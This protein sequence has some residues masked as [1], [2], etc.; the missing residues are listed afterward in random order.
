MHHVYKARD[1]TGM[2][3]N[4]K[5][6]NLYSYIR[7]SSE[8]Q[9]QG[10]SH[11]RQASQARQFAL[12][13][14]LN[15]IEVLDSGVSAYR[16]A[17][18]S[19]G[20]LGSFIAAVE[21][22]AIPS[23]SWLYV[24]NLDRISRQAIT[25]SQEL[26]LK[27]LRLG[28]TIVTGI[29]G[30]IYTTETVN[31]NPTD[32]MLSILLFSRAH[33]ESKTK[34]DRTNKNVLTLIDRHNAGLPVNIK[35]AGKHPFWIDDSGSQYETVRLHA[36]YAPAAKKSIE[37]FL[38]GW[39]SYRVC[40]YLNDHYEC[41]PALKYKNKHGTIRAEGWSITALRKMRDNPALFGQRVITIQNKTY[42]LHNYYPPLI[43][44]SDFIKL[45]SIK[46]NN[47]ITCNK[48]YNTISLLSGLNI[49]RCAKC[50]GPMSFFTHRNK[51]RYVCETGKSQKGCVPW[52]MDG[53]IA[54]RLLV[55]PLLKSFIDLKLKGMSNVDQ[56]QHK[57]TELNEALSNIN[58]QISNYEKVIGAGINLDSTIASLRA[59]QSQRET[60]TLELNKVNE[61]AAL[62]NS[63][64]QTVEQIVDFLFDNLT[65]QIINDI[66][67]PKRQ[68]LRETIRNLFSNVY[69]DKR[70]DKTYMIAFE[71][72]DDSFVVYSGDTTLP[73]SNEAQPKFTYTLDLT[74]QEDHKEI[75][76]VR[77]SIDPATLYKLGDLTFKI[78]ELE[79]RL[80]LKMQPVL[81]RFTPVLNKELKARK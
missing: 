29:D 4:H 20:A 55:F 41:P 31:T 77:D 54:E 68:E 16:G 46:E 78:N 62:K 17:N 63:R 19:Q 21:D 30:R 59:L 49:L 38:Q 34:S 13:H 9:G 28:L 40:S 10:T 44:E 39:G 14:G 2:V 67:H 64:E 1:F 69:L 50:R 58:N 15:F 79:E 81:S 32:L 57:I 56:Y 76:I 18:A 6:Q 5:G 35:A 72:Q 43:S 65:E 33:E 61:I 75:E 25:N 52:S 8:K 11:A 42:T 23:D 53:T 26:F 12:E 74:E 71:S 60:V 66:K 24:E 45:K 27:L 80:W 51:I 70:N 37:L 47:K 3:Q 73:P 22:G 48:R 7:W 36:I